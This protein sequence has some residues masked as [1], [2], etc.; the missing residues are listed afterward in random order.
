T[1]SGKLDRK[2][3]PAP[4]GDAF[5]RRGYEAPLGRTE[6]ALAEIWAEL[7]R[8]E[9]VG[10][11]DNFFELGGH[12]LLIVKLIARMRRRGLHADVGTLFT[13]PVLAELARVVRGETQE[14]MVP[15]N[16]IP[17]D[18]Q[19]IT[20]EMLPL[21]ALSPAEI[22]RV[23]AG[24][25]G[26]AANVQ[27]VYPLAP[28]QE[29]ILFHHL[30]AHEGDPYLA[31]ALYGF[32]TREQLDAYVAALQAV[33]DRHDIL[34]TAIAWDGLPEPVQVVW[35]RAQ[36]RVE[37]VRPDAGEDA[38][39][40]LWD[41]YDP[42]RTRLDLRQAPLM[43]AAMAHDAARDR[44]L[45]LV[46]EHHLIGDHTTL[47][48]LREEIHAHQQGRQAELPAPQ[49][50]RTFVAQ[51]RLGVSRAEHEA[52]FGALL[53]DVTEPT[54]PFGLLD[55]W[56]DGTGVD[57]A[58]QWVEPALEARLRARARALGVSAAAVCH[59][60]WGQVLA[61]VT[62]RADV[63]FGTV[64]FGRMQ[65]GEGSDR[66]M[67]LFMNTLPVRVR[68]GGEGA[69]ASV[70]QMH[71]QLAQLLRHEH[72]SLGLAQ[73]SS[74][75]EAPAPLF[76][77]FLNYRH[78]VARH[79]A[80]SVLAREASEGMHRLR[81]EDRS[82]Y[83]V[84]LSVNDSD[85]GLELTA[86]APGSVGAALVCA[87]MD[88]ALATLVDALDG[89]PE[90]AV[91]SLDVLPAAERRRVV[92]EW[93]RT[94]AE[95]PND[96][97][98]HELFQAQV[99]RAPDATAVVFAGT[100]LT[101]AELN[102]RANRLAHHLRG[103]GV[104]PHA[105]VAI[106]VE[107]SPEMVVGVLGV[108]K[109]GGAWV[110][111]DP[112]YPAER[113]R[114]MLEDGA[115]GVVLTQASIAAARPELF[116]GLG[117][118]VLCLDAP[119]WGDAPDTDP[120]RGGLTPDDLAYVIY[121]SGSTGRPKG[122]MVAHR[123]AANLVAA[124][125]LTLGVRPE[126]R[127]LQFA[128]F[129]FD[130]SVFEMVM[131]LC[132]GA[133]LHVPVGGDLLAGEAL[134]RVVDEGR[135]THVTLPPAVLPTLSGDAA[136]ASVET[137]VLAGEAV[138]A[139]AVQ[140][141]A[142]RTRLL[143]AYGPTEA[144]VWSTVHH[145]RADE[146]GNP[147]IGR[148]IAN[149]RVYVLD[150]AGE[151]APVGV[152]GELYIGGAGVARG[153]LG[154]PEL[155]A[156]RF[157]A[158]PFGDRPGARLYRTGDLARRRAD[159]TLEFL[160]R[161][162]FQVKVRGFR[163]E[164]GEIEARLREHPGVREAAVVARRDDGQDPQ[165]VAYCVGDDVG[166]DALRRH[167]GERLPEYMVPA[168]FVL[169]EALPLTPNGKLDRKA[170]PSPQGEAYARRGY[171]A[172]VGETEQALAEIWSEVLGVD[173]VGRWD[174]F[175]ELGGH[176]LLVVLV[177]SRIRQVLDAEVEA[178]TIF[179]FPVLTELAEALAGAGEAGL[180][181]I[182][183][184]DRA[185]RLPLSYAQQR[186]WFLEQMGDL[187]STYH[188]PQRLRLH[189]ALDRDA[190]ARALDRL[191]ARHEVLRTTFPVRDGTPEQRI[192]PVT[193]PFALVEQDLSGDVEALERV[194]AGEAMAPF[195]LAQGPL[196]RGRLL[197]LADDDH[198][199]LLT[200]HHI[201][202]DGWSA[203]V[204]VGELSRLYAA[205][206]SGG[207]D[208]LPPLPVQYAD[209]AAWQRRWVEDEVLERQAA[210]WTA[211]LK[212]APALLAL[213]ADHPRPARPDHAGGELRVEL[214][215]ALTAGLREL[216]RRHGATLFMTLLAGWAT[217]L[218][219]LS[220]QRD[221]VIG[222]PTANRGRAE[223]EGLIGYFLN[224]LALR[225]DLSDGPT[226]AQLLERVRARA[227]EAQQNQDIPFE[228]VVERVD[229][230]RSLSHTPLFQV[231]FT[232]QNAPRG[233]I[234]L[235]G[236]QLGRVPG[237]RQTTAKFDLTLALA[238]AGDRVVGSL[239]YATSLFERGTVER[240]LG[241][242]RRVLEQMVAGDTQS[243]DALELLPPT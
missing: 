68:V 166:A 69:E 82:N 39:Q 151:P 197:R 17:A 163:I 18:A 210:Y 179:D 122:V 117:A 53:G 86:Q 67:G 177:I 206:R 105:R 141:W 41:R 236:L 30:L 106:C 195:D 38:G 160:G 78:N 107:R 33:I 227:V 55:T 10:R 81:V 91:G 172:P 127:V 32:D 104:G 23:V 170:L 150:E 96:V 162:D 208:P 61:R 58:R 98:V 173:R 120:A 239:E 188:V 20:P 184:V 108:L 88:R 47:E 222:T 221:V 28:L 13:T 169:L 129:S 48:V 35:R 200:M 174:D 138:P 178:A 156:E 73:R 84:A 213:P 94:D 193:T 171:E 196:I 145:C 161:N 3:L 57:A 180:P 234:E 74:G 103:L 241:Y 115:P 164:L 217:V 80:R 232:L 109:A 116:A 189:G 29:G 185:G 182:E 165:L 139:A 64:L 190:L 211:T 181:P 4:E 149:T 228:Q 157:V 224:T 56:S 203:G 114:Y 25:P 102:A 90:R 128:S 198:V 130:A 175:F 27:D 36:L 6:Q 63:V 14:A 202:A 152:P 219:R 223:I 237:A 194:M 167:V 143:N 134:E 83:P 45:L 70:R 95:T 199:L 126:S 8:V 60:A 225:V 46:Q 92:E 9:R 5:A 131:A 100:S 93:N 113:L 24:V 133:S 176:S 204:L 209:Y 168:A 66:A 191:V 233:S 229:P 16:A 215:E 51:A 62:G 147:P 155:T 111:L 101:Y 158:D 85:D 201:V 65:G 72:A 71:G 31:S 21:V 59:V 97:C 235:P 123:N 140:R 183:R 79:E 34:R 124:Q 54:A 52:Y 2:A 132:Q 242:F 146:R 214:D 11:W 87:L 142:G 1:A 37:A 243:V 153:Y 19:A 50:F 218:G 148:P 112:A 12:S 42:R 144:A 26:G 110:P 40:A 192:A 119:V 230:V 136:F 159:G 77:S 186:L 75:V 187:G 238:E 89:A 44:W 76:T 125:A 231:L 220:G 22:D 154:R 121:T 226:V 137:M 205:F 240:F 43:R 99:R 118:E 7:L 216:G 15:A 135:I 212:G 207:S 49:P